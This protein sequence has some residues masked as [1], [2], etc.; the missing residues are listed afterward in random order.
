MAAL[1]CRLWAYNILSALMAV[2]LAL[3]EG[4]KAKHDPR[5]TLEQLVPAKMA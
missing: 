4:G 2:V 3:A 5:W 1:P